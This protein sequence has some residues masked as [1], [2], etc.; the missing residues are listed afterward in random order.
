MRDLSA[1]YYHRRTAI[2]KERFLETTAG[3]V[4][5]LCYGLDDTRRLPLFVNI[6][7]G[8]FVLGSPEM[9]DPFMPRIVNEA[10]VKIVSID[11][12]LA[13]E[14]PFPEPLEQ[15]YAV[16]KYVQDHADEFRID[17]TRIAVGGHSAGGY[18]SAAICVMNAMRKELNLKAAILDYPALDLYTP[19]SEKPLGH[20][21]IARFY[22]NRSRMHLY[23]SCYCL[24]VEDRMDPLVSPI[25]ASD[26]QLRAFP[27]TLIITAGRDGLCAE[28]ERFSEMLRAV[29]VDVTHKRFEKA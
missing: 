7:G 12:G 11:Y 21:I 17:P 24:N 3:Q 26:D 19:I 23:D 5:V 25:L 29:G 20:G 4:R 14:H 2:G 18:F 15:C 13:P 28:A 22:L 6:H 9:D 27:P 8:G 1:R 10:D 16:I